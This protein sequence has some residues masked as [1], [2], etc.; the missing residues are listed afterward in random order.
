MNLSVKIKEK[1]IFSW[2]G[3]S[4]ILISWTPAIIYKIRLQFHIYFLIQNID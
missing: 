4:F 1:L 3:S 2:S